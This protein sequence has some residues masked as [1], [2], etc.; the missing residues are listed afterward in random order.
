MSTATEQV[1]AKSGES[2]TEWVARKHRSTINAREY[3]GWPTDMIVHRLRTDAASALRGISRESD[4][5]MGLR[6]S[7]W[8][9]AFWTAVAEEL[10]SLADEFEAG[11]R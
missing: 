2:V 6:S 5:R 10:S 11:T 1:T 4:L 8:E 3:Y 7:E 9:I